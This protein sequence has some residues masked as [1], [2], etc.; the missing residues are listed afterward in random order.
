MKTFSQFIIESSKAKDGAAEDH[1]AD[2]KKANDVKEN[3]H[4][5][6][7]AEHSFTSKHDHHAI[8]KAYRSYLKKPSDGD[9]NSHTV[10]S[11]KGVYHEADASGNNHTSE[12]TTHNHNIENADKHNTVHN[13]D[14]EHKNGVW[15]H[16][17]GQRENYA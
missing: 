11:A 5:E 16:G 10:H 4:N 8:V 14:S 1:E 3:S 13:I 6:F 7:E 17:I 9:Y 12:F 2:F 15:H